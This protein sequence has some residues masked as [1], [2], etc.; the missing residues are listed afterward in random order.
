MLVNNEWIL[1]IKDKIIAIKGNPCSG[2]IVYQNRKWNLKYLNYQKDVTWI[3][4]LLNKT[5]DL[6]YE[7]FEE[8]F[9]RFNRTKYTYAYLEN[10]KNVFAKILFIMF[11]L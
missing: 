6:L 5:L 7:N 1:T 4:L 8:F 2:K 3:N 9:C 10:I 11:F